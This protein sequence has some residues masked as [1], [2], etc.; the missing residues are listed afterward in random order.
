MATPRWDHWQRIKPL[1]TNIA[2]RWRS[3]ARELEKREGP[4]R[5]DEVPTAAFVFVAYFSALNALY[6][7][8]S[9][10]AADVA[11]T[12]D[13][14]K[15]LHLPAEPVRIAALIDRLDDEAVGRI[16]RHDEVQRS[17]AH[18]H[19]RASAVRDMRF[20]ELDEE[21]DDSKGTRDLADMKD[22]TKPPRDKLK[23][24]AKTVYRVRCN[25]VH[26]SK[27]MDTT[28]AALVRAAVAP[29]RLLLDAAIDFTQSYEWPT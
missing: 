12:S 28:D 2:L 10:V 27:Q 23:A 25:L 22:D 3:T 7:F 16:W 17:V 26:G 18:L 6:W 9:S 15:E 4:D 1:Q 13:E 19:G 11:R 5:P 24:L 20:R 8:W 29:L 21:G 14:L